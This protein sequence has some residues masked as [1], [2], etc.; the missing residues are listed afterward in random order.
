VNA[1]EAVLG[2]PP[3]LL[4]A[5]V[6]ALPLLGAAVLLLTGRRWP[7]RSS[8]WLATGLVGASFGLSLVLLLDLLGRPGEERALAVSVFDWVATGRFSVPVSLRLDPLSAVMALT[9]TGVGALIHLY[10]VD[11][12]ATDPR[13]PRF[14]G[15]M[16]LF[17]FFMLALVLADNF[18]LLYLGW[19]GVGLCSYLLIGYWFERPAAAAAAKKAFVTTRVGDSAFLVGLLLLWFRVGS[20]EF[21]A[22]FGRAEGLAAGT[23]TV[24]SLLLFAGAVGK[25]AQ[26]PLHVWL[27][28]AMEGPTPVS[29]LIHAATMV[30]AGV[31]LVVR[32]HPLFE[33]SGAALDVVAVVGALTAVYAGLSAVG[34]DDIKRMLAY[35]TMSTLGFMFLG[36]GVGAYAA[37]IFLLVTHAFFKALL[38]LGAGSVMHGLGDETDMV[39]MG[40]LWRAMPFTF[41]TWAVG[42]L[43]MAGVPPLSGFFSKD[44]VVA[45]AAH[46]G[47]TGLW[48]LA[49]V[50]TFLTALYI[51]RGTFVA[52]LGPPRHGGHP[53]E[54]P[55]LMRVA[56]LVLAAG[57][58]AGGVL[59]LSAATGLL[60]RFLEPVLGA[61]QELHA[62][63]SEAVLAAV[64]VAVALA[65]VAVAWFVYL[66]GR[67][68]WLALR[69]RLWGWKRALLR[70]L[71]LEDVY[72]AALVGPATLAAAFAAYVVDLRLIDGA[73]EGLGRLVARAAAAGRRVQTG[74]VRAYALAFLLGAVGV[75]SYVV[76]RA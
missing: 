52:F 38:F 46:A 13:Y 44:Q 15:Y 72:A 54:A 7:G 48:V 6:P 71:Y 5:L 64:S 56:L 53:H 26:L 40:G 61:A 49:L 14:F 69:A 2:R 21:D 73:V 16:N 74:L 34:Q 12:M 76:A 23:A 68:D 65:G 37:A 11:Y 1:A 45:A 29:A 24:V 27:P 30:T 39:R 59:G 55:P 35:S 22:V 31:Y 51:S 28:D 17:V 9:V 36:A 43:A 19:E 60:P 8:G 4:L 20:L 63:P 70:G 50:G 41:A 3:G 66:S 18:L 47:R 33:A 32:A 62:G 42:W 67:I 57:A 75:L 58:A 25:S 10:S